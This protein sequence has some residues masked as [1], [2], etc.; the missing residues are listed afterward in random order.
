MVRLGKGLWE[1]VK[2]TEG[3][4]WLKGRESN[5]AANGDSAAAAPGGEGARGGG[6]LLNRFLGNFLEKQRRKNAEDA[7]REGRGEGKAGQ[8]PTVVD[9]MEAGLG[10]EGQLGR[11]T[12]TTNRGGLVGVG[13]A[14]VVAA[15]G[16]SA[17][18]AAVTGVASYDAETTM[19]TAAAAEEKER[20]LSAELSGEAATAPGSQSATPNKKDL[21]LSIM[22]PK[23]KDTGD[24]DAK[25]V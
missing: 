17:A 3:R 22:S 4:R 21:W 7:A 6:G 20:R 19:T 12:T 23:G 1:H 13:A 25:Q 10:G 2:S 9:D 15:G 8:G 16:G 24:K 11:A 18:G 14:D 5:A